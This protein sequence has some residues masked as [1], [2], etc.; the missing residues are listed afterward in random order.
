MVDYFSSARRQPKHIIRGSERANVIGGPTVHDLRHSLHCAISFRVLSLCLPA[1]LFAAAMIIR[2]K[3]PRE[4]SQFGLG[5]VRMKLKERTFRATAIPC[6]LIMALW[7]SRARAQEQP[8]AQELPRLS[9]ITG[10]KPEVLI[11]TVVPGAPGKLAIVTRVTYQPGARIRKHYH[12]GQVVFYILEGTMVVQHEDGS[13][14][15]LKAGDSL[16]IKPATVHAHWNAS[17]AVPVVFTEFI[18]VD[19]GQRTAVFVE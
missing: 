11:R 3:S 13:L 5:I 18:I 4:Q 2:N 1:F 12:T 19:E 15:T 7:S 9:E 16:L 17:S 8:A 6:V 14:M 10:I